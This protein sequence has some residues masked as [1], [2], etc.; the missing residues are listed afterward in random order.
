VLINGGL[1]LVIAA[2]I[3]GGIVLL[4][5]PKATSA[6]GTQLTSTVQQGTVS[7][8]ITAS[9]A[10]APVKEVSANFGVSG[11]VAA[12]NVTVG[13]TVRKGQRIAS[14]QTTTYQTAASE[15][16][17]AYV[18]AGENVT[19]AASQKNAQVSQ[20]NSAKQAR[21]QAWDKYQSAQAD[22]ASTVLYAPAS[23]LVIAVNGEVGGSSGGSGASSSSSSSSGF[24]TIAVTSQLTV[25]ANIAEADI[26]NVTVGQAA[27]VSFPAI[28][29]TTAAAKVTAIAPTATSSNSIVT[30]ATTITLTE[31]PKGIRLGQTANVAI[32]VATSADNAL[33]VPSA[34]ITTATDGTSTVK[35]VDAK[36]GQLSSVTVTL[37]VVGDDGTEIKSGLTAGE[38]VSLGTASTSTTG[39]T[40]T[41]GTNRSRFGGFGGTGG[42]FGGGT[43]PGGGN[44]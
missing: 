21:A 32:T 27:V 41:T 7:Q 5:P 33:Y 25:T 12:V 15:A 6:T 11:T 34:A 10:I 2:G 35:V 24:A 1:V 8:T 38:T 22:L 18:Y 17:T 9:G 39:T 28:T 31:I 20:I 37:G 42:N 30:Y 14:L 40:G 19:A 36:T 43:P 29:G 13:Q 23:G 26:A 44:G 16:W 3:V 4:N